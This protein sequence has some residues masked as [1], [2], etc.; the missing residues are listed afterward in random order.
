MKY[1]KNDLGALTE[2]VATKSAN[3]YHETVGLFS[4]S[5]VDFEIIGGYPDGTFK[6]EQTINF[7]ESAKIVAAAF[8]LPT[9]PGGEWWEPSITALRDLDFLPPSYSAPD[10]NI[11]RGELAEIIYRIDVLM[12]MLDYLEEEAS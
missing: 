7:A 3:R 6:P 5:E 12:E 2:P 1:R 11:T 4:S 10:R 9:T 8:A